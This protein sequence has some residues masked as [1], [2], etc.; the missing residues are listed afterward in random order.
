MTVRVD[1]AETTDDLDALADEFADLI[2][3]R[4]ALVEQSA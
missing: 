4:R 1:A 3:Y 2:L